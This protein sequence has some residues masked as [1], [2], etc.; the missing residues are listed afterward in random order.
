MM[1][2][3]FSLHANA[4]VIRCSNS[5]TTAAKNRTFQQSNVDDT[6]QRAVLNDQDLVLDKALATLSPPRQKMSAIH[7]AS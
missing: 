1:N 3:N 5:N 6:Y 7:L 2:E 4:C